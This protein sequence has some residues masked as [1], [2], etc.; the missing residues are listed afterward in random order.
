[1]KASKAQ[2]KFYKGVI[3]ATIMK[4]VGDVI[5]VEQLDS[6]IKSV[7]DIDMSCIELSKEQMTDLCRTGIMYANFL[8]AEMDIDELRELTFLDEKE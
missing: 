8:G 7:I 6:Q 1:M 5:T 2:I 4:Y 3:L